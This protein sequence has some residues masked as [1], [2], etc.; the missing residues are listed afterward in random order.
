MTLVNKIINAIVLGYMKKYQHQKDGYGCGLA[1]LANLLDLPYDKIKEGW[2][3]DF[4]KLTTYTYVKDIKKFLNDRGLKY[5]SKFFNQNKKYKYNKEEGDK[6]SQ[7]LGSITL[8]A[9]NEKYPTGHYLL[10]VKNGWVDP[11]FNL[12]SIDK[13]HAGVKK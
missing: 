9:K 2:E 4:Y 1:C 11:W 12:P 13:V 10:R 3:K 8:I 7:I 5:E 6:Y